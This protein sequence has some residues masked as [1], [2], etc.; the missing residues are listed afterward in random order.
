MC[1]CHLAER[2][3]SK[4]Q[5]HSGLP[6]VLVIQLITND[7]GIMVTRTGEKCLILH[8]IIIGKANTAFTG[9]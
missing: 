7:K 4:H 2:F 1:K 6:F 3:L 8:F 5:H 9:M